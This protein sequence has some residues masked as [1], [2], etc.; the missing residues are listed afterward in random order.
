MM[1]ARTRLVALI[2]FV[3]AILRK[4]HLRFP[5][6]GMDKK[7]MLCYI[8]CM[9]KKLDAGDRAF[10]D[11]VRKST[12]ENPFGASR[13]ASDK[14]AVGVKGD[15]D[16]M[17]VLNRLLAD[18]SSRLEKIGA[19][20]AIDIRDYAADDRERLVI[21]LLF[22]IFHRWRDRTDAYIREQM[23]HGEELLAWQ[24]ADSLY[25]E[26]RSHGMEPAY[27]AVCVAVFFQFRRA[28]YF[29]DGSLR[30]RSPSMRRLR[31]QLW[32]AV[33]TCDTRAYVERLWN[34]LEDFSTL[35]LGETGTGK[36]AAAMALGR[37][38]FIP[39]VPERRSF[40]ESFTRAF[41]S[42]NLSQYAENLIES[43]LFGHRKGAFTGAVES[44]DGIFAR[45][46][47]CGAIFLDEIGDVSEPIQIKLLQVLQQ[48]TFSPVGGHEALRF[49]GRVIAATNQDLSARRA[50]GRFRNDFFYRLSSGTIELPTLRRRLDEDE[51]EL[52][53]LVADIVER[54][55][56]APDQALAGRIVETLGRDLPPGYAWPGN[57]RELEQASRSVLLTGHYTGD[58]CAAAA[59]GGDGETR[60]VMSGAASLQ[61]VE[62]W[63]CRRL[64]GR[65]GAYGPVAARL[66][67]DWR[68]VKRLVSTN[69]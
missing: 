49:S 56:G 58:P 16:Q 29:I 26:M 9:I 67:V 11:Q 53:L 24:G 4:Q 10:F 61:E 68:T 63:Y 38:G 55:V 54:L 1:R 23:A 59:D 39:Y 51:G 34:R 42:I 8:G 25:R 33:F 15:A 19:G 7:C 46:S 5:Q 41:L 35:L 20:R 28:F 6:N 48:R 13:L 62:R 22:H 52:G 17:E 32:N 27:A 60:R 44:H 3:H 47:P 50:E 31:E 40:Q 69:F 64:Y 45:C 37:S 21:A 30:G 43:E 12:F 2:L 36:G 66:G 14:S 57:V 65:L 18:L